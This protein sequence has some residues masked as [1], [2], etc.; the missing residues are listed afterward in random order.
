MEQFVVSQ[1]RLDSMVV[2]E[3]SGEVDLA[4]ADRLRS[5]LL[6]SLTE[7]PKVVVVRLDRVS[8]LDSAGIS[9]LVAGHKAALKQDTEFRLAAPSPIVA[10]TLRMTSID[11]Y[12]PTFGNV[13]DAMNVA[14]A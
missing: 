12:I 14:T 4:T 5:A 13:E 2:V 3:P 8:F 7:A 10:K 6:E 11:E 1:S 9:A